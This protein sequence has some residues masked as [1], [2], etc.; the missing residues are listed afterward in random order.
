MFQHLGSH[1]RDCVHDQLSR[2]V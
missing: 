1:E 2:R